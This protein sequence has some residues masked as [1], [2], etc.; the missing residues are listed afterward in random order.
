LKFPIDLERDD[1]LEAWYNLV[2]KSALLSGAILYDI[3]GGKKYAENNTIFTVPNNKPKFL[4]KHKYSVMG[5]R[6]FRFD[7]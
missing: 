1:P 5:Q 7:K 2:I 3:K 4:K 6:L